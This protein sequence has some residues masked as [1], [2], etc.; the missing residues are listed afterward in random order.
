[1]TGSVHVRHLRFAAELRPSS[2]AVAELIKRLVPKAGREPG[3]TTG[4]VLVHGSRVPALL[5]AL[6]HRGVQV[7]EVGS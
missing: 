1:M 5:D 2:P 7:V 6:R 3:T 4:S